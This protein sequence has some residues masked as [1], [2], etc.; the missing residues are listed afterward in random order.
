MTK[1]YKHL[2]SLMILSTFIL[3]AL[4]C[5]EEGCGCTIPSVTIPSYADSFDDN[6]EN[7]EYQECGIAEDKKDAEKIHV[8]VYFNSTI[9][10]YRCELKYTKPGNECSS[11]SKHFG[12]QSIST[13]EISKKS[14]KNGEWKEY[15]YWYQR[16]M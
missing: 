10:K 7:W 5:G 12:M 15:S 8:Y 3:L 1:Y 9:D 2:A 16:M 13:A 11:T 6:E 14:Y 4:S